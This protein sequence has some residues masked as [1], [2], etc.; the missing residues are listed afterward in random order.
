MGETNRGTRMKKT[1]TQGKKGATTKKDTTKKAPAKKVPAK[2]VPAKKAPVKK[3]PA[4]NVPSK[5]PAKKVITKKD[6]TTK[7]TKAAAVVKA[8]A[9]QK[10]KRKIRTSPRFYRPKTLKQRRKPKYPRIARDSESVH[11]RKIDQYTIIKYPLATESAMK[12]I[13]ENNTLVF[14]VDVRANKF[15]IQE[16]VKNMYDI[17]TAK[18]NTL[19]R[20]N[21]NKKAYVRLTP[22]AEA[23]EIANKIGI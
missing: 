12:K 19:I 9:F 10:A 18:I 14:V 22:D 11:R 7:A 3:I 2:N 1:G 15:Q 20:P 8:G 17:K 6:A 4:K 5:V 23:L 21:G 16:A 13:E